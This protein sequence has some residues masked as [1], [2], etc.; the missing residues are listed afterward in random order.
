M[1][2]VTAYLEAPYVNWCWWYETLLII[3]RLILG[4][5]LTQLTYSPFARSMAAS[6]VI[7]VFMTLDS[8]FVP[9]KNRE[10]QV[11]L[12][13]LQSI[14][15]VLAVLPLGEA[16]LSSLNLSVSITTS[17]D[18]IFEALSNAQVVLILV[19]VLYLVFVIGRIVVGAVRSFYR[20]CRRKKFERRRCCARIRR[21]THRLTELDYMPM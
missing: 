19:G 3:R 18:S 6:C 20:K 9:F 14:L 21:P 7:L 15:A 11:M 5:I 4:S 17:Q 13:L 16:F 1:S 12:S 2:R 8:S 10:D